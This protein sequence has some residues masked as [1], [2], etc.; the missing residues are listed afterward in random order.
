MNLSVK[1]P[2]CRKE[3]EPAR[4]FCKHCGNKMDLSQVQMNRH[5]GRGLV[6]RS[7]FV[8]RLVLLILLVGSVGLML[9]PA[10]PQGAIGNPVAG[11]RCAFMLDDLRT[12]MLAG[13]RLQ[14]EFS[15][16]EVNAYLQR[17]LPRSPAPTG[18]TTP[19]LHLTHISLY[20]SETELTLHLQSEWNRLRMTHRVTAIPRRG[21]R[22]YELEVV[23][24]S[25]GHLP[26]VGPLKTRYAERLLSIFDPMYRERAVLSGLHQ[27]ETADGWAR[28]VVGN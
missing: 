26:L 18:L 22:G 4:L 13:N 3:N 5:A 21:E 8:F 15:E 9:W 16:E 19:K 7:L 20:F 12:A 10:K 23:S 2:V 14:R 6:H 1:C 28:L 24:V 17:L 27:L 25:I 11:E